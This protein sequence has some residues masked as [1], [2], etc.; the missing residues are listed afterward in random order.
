MAPATFTSWFS[1]ASNVD[2]MKAA[3]IKDSIKIFPD[4]SIMGKS[5]KNVY[6]LK[7]SLKGIRPPIWRRIQ[8]P[9]YYTFSDLHT[10]IQNAMGWLDLHLHALKIMNP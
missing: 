9:D 10:A 5:F 3:V 8:V 6:Q 2:S 7:V 4:S 1:E